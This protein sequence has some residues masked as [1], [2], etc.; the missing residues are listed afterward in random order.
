VWPCG[1]PQNFS[2]VLIV[3]STLGFQ[4]PDKQYLENVAFVNYLDSDTPPS[5]QTTAIGL[6]DSG[7]AMNNVIFRN[8]NVY[9]NYAIF[10]LVAGTDY[11]V[12]TRVSSVSLQNTPDIL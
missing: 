6:Y 3:E 7:W 12:S 10:R 2:N 1:T 9:P 11:D 5:V 4:D 8:Y